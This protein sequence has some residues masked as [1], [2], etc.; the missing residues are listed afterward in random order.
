MLRNEKH[1]KIIYNY[2][3]IVAYIGKFSELR[4][5]KDIRKLTSITWVFCI[6]MKYYETFDMRN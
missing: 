1:L 3:I 4:I 6:L 5:L 2:T